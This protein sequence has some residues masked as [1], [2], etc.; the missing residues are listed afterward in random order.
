MQ[1]VLFEVLN[2]GTTGTVDNT[3]WYAGRARGVHNVE[4]VVE[5]E[6]RKFYCRDALVFGQQIAVRD[7]IYHR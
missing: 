5:R 3:L 2:Q 4:G 6:L 1:L 7:R